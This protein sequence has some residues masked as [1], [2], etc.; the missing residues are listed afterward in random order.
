VNVESLKGLIRE[1]P[2]LVVIVIAGLATNSIVTF[3]DFLDRGA[4]CT[5]FEAC[6]P[7]Q[8]DPAF[9][10][11]TSSPDGPRGCVL[12]HQ[13]IIAG[14]TGLGS[15]RTGLGSCDT[16][17]SFLP[18]AHIYELCCELTMLAQGVRIGFFSGESRDIFK[19]IRALQPTILAGVPLVFNRLAE[20]IHREIEELPQFLRWIVRWAVRTK[21]E[22][23]DQGE[24]H[25]LFLD[26]LFSKFRAFLGGR[27]RLIVS[28]A[29]PLLPSVYSVM[30]AIITTNIIQGYGAT[31]ISAAGCLQEIGCTNPE[32]VGPVSISVDLKFRAV[33]GMDYN[34]NGSPPSGELMFRGPTVFEGYFMNDKETREVLQNQWYA[35]GD[36]GCLTSDGEIQIID[37]V[38]E[39]VRLSDGECVSLDGL[40]QKYLGSYGVKSIYVFA[41][42]H[43]NRPVAVV[44]PTDNAVEDWKGRGIIDFANSEI[45]R[46]EVLKALNERADRLNLRK[47]E[48]ILNVMLESNVTSDDIVLMGQS[49]GKNWRALRSKYEDRLLELYNIRTLTRP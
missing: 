10:L 38:T 9:L 1:M 27:I 4:L 42:S 35:T 36:I 25:S 2:S 32:T 21:C 37:Q 39:L 8:G 22:A 13:N 28:G 20:I 26:L 15:A 45:A 41:D 23:L 6:M 40:T 19:D 11:Y 44:V 18:L 14:A 7:A 12:T 31:E 24:D 16:Y 17:F 47:S 3:Q 33:E 48:R 46:N 34:P 5:D 29:A 43:H 30:R 49:R